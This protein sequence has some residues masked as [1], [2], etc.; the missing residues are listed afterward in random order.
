[1]GSCC[2]ITMA[3]GQSPE[4]LLFY[5][6]LPQCALTIHLA[7]TEACLGYRTQFLNLTRIFSS[8]ST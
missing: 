1:M 7:A 2:R 6:D 3:T 4:P 5:A 8:W